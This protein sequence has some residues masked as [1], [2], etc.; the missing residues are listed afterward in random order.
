MCTQASFHDE[1]KAIL[2]MEWPIHLQTCKHYLFYDAYPYFSFVTIELLCSLLSQYSIIVLIF[3]GTQSQIHDIG[4]F[5]CK[6]LLSV[7]IINVKYC[8]FFVSPI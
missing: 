8:H 7:L 5:G 2:L 1:L 6:N 4:A 3:C